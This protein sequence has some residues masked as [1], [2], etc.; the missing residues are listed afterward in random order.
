LLEKLEKLLPPGLS[1][2]EREKA[3]NAALTRWTNRMDVFSKDYFFI[4]CHLH[5]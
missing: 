1:A 2:E 3:A 5:G 4:P